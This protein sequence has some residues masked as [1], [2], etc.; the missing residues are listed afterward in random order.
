[1][2]TQPLIETREIRQQFG[3]DDNP[4]EILHGINL[5]IQAGEMVAL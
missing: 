1:M 3:S 5:T 4:L 2:S